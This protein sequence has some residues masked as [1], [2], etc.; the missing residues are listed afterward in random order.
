MKKWLL[1]A[2]LL[3][4][5]LIVAIVIGADTN[6]FPSLLQPLYDFPGGDKAGHFILF[7]ILSFLLNKSALVLFPKRT[8]ARLVLTVSLLLSI[9]IGLE[10]W[11]QSLFPSRTMSLID[12]GA[13]YMGVLVFALLAY[14]TRR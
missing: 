3:F 14:W 1:L 5:I 11:S 13:S 2:T 10:E 8:P 6:H 12:L 4:S 7:G 9:V